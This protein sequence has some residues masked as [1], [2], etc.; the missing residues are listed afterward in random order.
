MEFSGLDL[1]LLHALQVDGR[2]PFRRIADVLG[3][4]DQTVARRYTRLRGAGALRVVGFSDPTAVDD[5]QWMVRVRCAPGA[6]PEIA[7]ALARRSDTSWIGL[8]SG[9]T[10]ITCSVR[11][12]GGS[13][14]DDLLL[15]RLP[16]TPRVVDVSVQQVLHTFF[17][18]AREPFAKHGVLDV[19]QV[20]RLAAHVPRPAS[21][22]PAPKLDDVDRSLLR[23]LRDDG[24]M[25]V[26]D[27]ARATGTSASTVR[28][29][30]QEL[31]AGGVLYLDV[32]SDPG[33]LD[34]PVRTQLWMS[35]APQDLETAGRAV[36]AHLE[37]PFAAA[38][39]GRTN[40]YAVAAHPDVATFYRYLTT[41]IA[42]LPGVTTV[43][44]SPT[45]RTVKLADTHYP[46]D[47]RGVPATQRQ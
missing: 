35:V 42:G 8:T 31:R 1:A 41:S 32:D 44:T 23:A 43:E 4:S 27:L 25:P 47:R 3:V 40:L 19:E 9:G 34:L 46:R 28:R 16:H 11:S 6:G 21:T 26:E 18:G 15:E 36:A 17:G 33:M 39:S 5:T 22:A 10:E 14:T 2:A 29:R 37:V 24:R 30:L 12:T 13:G 20:R 38:T 45:M 7:D